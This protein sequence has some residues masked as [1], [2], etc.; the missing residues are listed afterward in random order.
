MNWIRERIK[1]KNYRYVLVNG[2]TSAGSST[3]IDLLMEYQNMY[4]PERV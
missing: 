1:V 4:A 3:V 2:Y